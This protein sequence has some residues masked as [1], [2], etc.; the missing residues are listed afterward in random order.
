MRDPFQS[1][2]PRRRLTPIEV[3]AWIDS[4]IF[5]AGRVVAGAFVAVSLF[6]RRFRVSGA[7]RVAFEFLGDATNLAAGAAVLLLALALPAFQATKGDWRSKGDLAITFLDRYGNEIGQRGLKQSDAVPL[8][9][10]PDHLIKAVL[11]T[12][13]RRFFDHFGI[14]VPGTLRAMVENL[15][16]NAVVQGGSSLSQQL[17][18]NLFLSNERTID[19]KIKEAFLALWLEANLSK[20]EILKLYLDRA[21]MGGGAFGVEAASEF[22]FGKSVKD[23]SLSEA[24]LLAG[25]FKAPTRYAPHVNLPAARARANEVLTNMVQAGFMTEGQVVGARRHPADVIE[26]AQASGSPDYFLDWAFEKVKEMNLSGDRV[27]TVRTT[28]DMGMQK[29][30]E[31]AI[32]S[33]L[34]Q[35]GNSY[36]VKQ[37][38]MVAVDPDGAVRAMVGGRD[39]GES[40]FNR[41][42]DALRQPGSSFKP[43]VYATAMMNGFTPKSV[44]VDSPICIGDWCPKNYSG[45]YSGSITLTTAIVNSINVIPVK[46]A[47]A[48][49]RDKIV[50]TARRMGITSELRITRS[51]PLGSSEVSVVDMAGAYSVFAN[52]GYKATPYPFTQII[53]GQ[54]DV[55]YDRKR[56]APPAERVLDDKVVSEMNSMLVQVPEIGTGKRAKLDGIRTAGKTGTTSAYRDAWFVGFTGN[57]AA[58]VWFGN[59][60]YAP[61]RRLTGGI[62]PAMAWKQFMTYAHQGIELKPIPFVQPPFEKPQAV[63]A[64]SDERADAAAQRA[65]SLSAATSERLTIIEGLMRNA[66]RLKPL[67]MLPADVGP[68]EMAGGAL[69]N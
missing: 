24:A 48:F 67:A 31:D 8:E 66:P 30:G 69:P 56:D 41:A 51:L 29:A 59:D 45:G 26:H 64:Q 40:Q 18:K 39:Y 42:T 6:L 27:L 14:D 28:I 13:D 33:T 3:D 11:A 44:V 22:Y 35:Y 61:T 65:S 7:A 4:A 2:K 49:G 63:V 5:R 57:Y 36:R 25:L 58:A 55:L 43:F 10:M 54:G 15:R 46:L 68:T 23:V 17:A 9:E 1:N 34:R 47:Q 52:G 62:L 20:Q 12:E 60:G 21:Y 37:G 32:E 50:D 38:A 19:R 53:S 16:A